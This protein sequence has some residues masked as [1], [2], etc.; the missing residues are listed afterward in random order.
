MP[1]IRLLLQNPHQVRNL[2]H[3]PADGRRIFSF[4]NRIQFPQPQSFDNQL[5]LLVEADRAPVILDFQ[6]ACGRFFL[7]THELPQ[8]LF[9]WFLA[10]SGNFLRIL[11]ITQSLERSLN[12]IVRV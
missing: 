8:N 6:L 11:K 3:H 1:D 5:L 12:D 9:K 7:R 4:A 10:K 2:R